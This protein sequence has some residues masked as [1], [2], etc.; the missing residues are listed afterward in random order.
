MRIFTRPRLLLALCALGVAFMSYAAI[1]DTAPVVT[2]SQ[3]LSSIQVDGV[4]QNSEP[5]IAVGAAWRTR[6]LWR[7]FSG[8]DANSAPP[9]PLK[10]EALT[11]DDLHNAPDLSLWRLGHSTILLKLAGKFWLTDPVFAERASPLGFMGPKRFQPAPIAR[12]DLPEIE[13]VILSH[14]H[15][16]HLDQETVLAVAPKVKHYLAPLG[17]GD[18]LINWGIPANKVQQLDWWQETQVGELRLV[19]TPARHF[20]GRS[21]TDRNKTLWASWV[22]IAPS[23]RIFF[24]GDSG[25]FSGFKS[26]GERF[27]PFDLTLLENGAYDESWPD[28]HMQ[29]EQTLQAHLDLKGKVLLPIHNGTFDLA[30]HAWTEPMER[31]GALARQGQLAL[32][33]PRIGERL[34]IKEPGHGIAWWR[35]ESNWAAVRAQARMASE[36]ASELRPMP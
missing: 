7:F 28:I 6:A 12:E 25:Y 1:F 4:F 26:I 20:S 24:G 23:V 14:D 11:P 27:G 32:S 30:L 10:A 33:T 17:V 13:A 18:R 34:D 22:L 29:P 5:E 21:L 31:I 36:P 35:Q 16:D 3:P 19:A 8:K 9:Q 15:Y 2:A